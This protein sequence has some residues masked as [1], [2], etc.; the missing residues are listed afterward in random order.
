[1]AHLIVSNLGEVAAVFKTA[2]SAG[3]IC[4]NMMLGYL[5]LL[6]NRNFPCIEIPSLVHEFTV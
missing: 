3:K 5:V 1:M 4:I 2:Y 6:K